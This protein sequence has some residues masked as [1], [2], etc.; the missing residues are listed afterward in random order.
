MLSREEERGGGRG[1]HVVGLG[2]LA[3]VFLL[4][5]AC[6]NNPTETT[7]V[8]TSQA[9]EAEFSVVLGDL[10]EDL[11]LTDEQREAIQAVMDA[12]RGQGR[13]PGTTWYAAADLQ[14]ILTSD[15]IAVI[16]SRLEEMAAEARGRREGFRERRGSG[17]PGFGRGE[18]GFHGEGLDLT[19]EQQTEIEAIRE[20]FQPR[21]EELRE[22]LREGSVSREE[23]REQ[24]EAIRA[25]MEAAIA[26][27]LTDDQLAV[28]E[29]WKAER[30]QSRD[31]APV[32]RETR[33]EAARVAMVEALSLTSDQLA[34]LD[35]LHE[36][37]REQGRPEDSDEAQARREEHRAALLE[38]LDD[39]QEEIWILHGALRAHLARHAASGTAERGDSGDR[40]GFGGRGGRGGPPGRGT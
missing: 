11:E 14:R 31:E 8:S 4:T 39:E 32:D 22:A 29:E 26:E 13:E 12:Y 27:V 6:S 17:G 28:L 38:I 3:G 16:G 15:Q 18:G 5:A 24:M 9:N 7:D 1:R 25:E 19:D 10:T 2:L 37:A 21:L 34:A 35:A 30:E 40:A 33:R 36:A 20:S 23:A